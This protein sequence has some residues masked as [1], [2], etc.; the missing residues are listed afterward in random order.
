MNAQQ[1]SCDVLII[2]AGLAG[3]SVSLSLPVHTRII[4]LAKQDLDTCASKR[5]QGGIAAVMAADDSIDEHIHDTLIA[6]D[7]RC[8]EKQVAAILAAGSEAIDWLQQLGVPFSLDDDGSLHLTREGGHGKRRVVHHADH[9]GFSITETLQQRLLQQGNVQWL[10]HL[11]VQA[12][13]L[14]AACCVGADGVDDAGLN[15]HIEA[16]HVVLATGGLGQL[17]ALTTNP[18]TATGDGVAL[19]AQAGCRTQDLAYVQFHPTALALPEN[20]CFL[21]SEAVRGEGGLLRNHVGERFMPHY[22]ARAELAPRDVVARAIATEMQRSQQNHVY[23]DSSHLQADFIHAHFPSI[24][25]HCL[26]QHQLD[27]S[28]TALPVAPAAHYACGGVLT[29]AWARTNVPN[30]YAVGEVSCTGLH[31][32]NRLASNSLLEC[33]VMGRK[34]AQAIASN[35]DW[36]VNTTQ[37]TTTGNWQQLQAL[38]LQTDTANTDLDAEFTP[39]KLQAAMSQYFGIVRDFTGMNLLWQQLCLWYQNLPEHAVAER[40][41]LITA[42]LMVHSGLALQHNQGAHYNRDLVTLA[43]ELAT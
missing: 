41:R 16:S 2:G 35:S 39:V 9:T 14:Q 11:Q 7:G 15:H 38:V 31:G 26:Q 34:A 25:A 24:H 43:A 6:G 21:I 4:I 40:L 17:F 8:D 29:D 13:R 23:L 18:L 5:A 32:A 1:H 20:P 37:P 36:P 30:L 28:T 19:A 42:L 22:D 10:T 27:M 33:V 12:L 3:L